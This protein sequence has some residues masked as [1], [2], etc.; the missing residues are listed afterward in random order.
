MVHTEKISPGYAAEPRDAR[1][2][3]AQAPPKSQLQ[4]CRGCWRECVYHSIRCD[5]CERGVHFACIDMTLRRAEQLTVYLCATCE[6][7]G[8]PAA[9]VKKARAEEGKPCK[10]ARP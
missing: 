4:K 2:Q 8:V 7:D 6:N 10:V 9:E 3:N 5:H 1:R